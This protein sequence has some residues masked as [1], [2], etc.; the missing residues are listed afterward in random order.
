[1]L[2]GRKE[3]DADAVFFDMGLEPAL[4]VVVVEQVAVG[5]DDVG[6]HLADVAHY[7]SAVPVG[8]ADEADL[9]LFAQA[10]DGLQGA[11]EIFALA[12]EVAVVQVLEVDGVRLEQF[13]GAFEAFPDVSGVVE[14]LVGA[15]VPAELACEEY[16][17]ARDF[18]PERTDDLFGIAVAVDI[19]GV[20]M[21]DALLV[22]GDQ[23]FPGI[24]VLLT[25]PAGG[26]SARADGPAVG[27]AT[28]ADGGD[29]DIGFTKGDVSHGGMNSGVLGG[30]KLFF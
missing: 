17:P 13:Q 9:S 5:L 2:E 29:L 6:I 10:K 22:G 3:G 18:F 28:E 14:M 16:V 26:R 25:G 21:A 27:P 15:L 30:D 12:P 7:F 23:G 4:F 24:G 20:P 19:G 8:K 1:M 11:V